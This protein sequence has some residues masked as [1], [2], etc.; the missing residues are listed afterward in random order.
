MVSSSR[1]SHGVPNP[2]S[3]LGNYPAHKSAR[4]KIEMKIPDDLTW[5]RANSACHVQ[6]L[7]VNCRDPYLEPTKYSCVA[8]WPQNIRMDQDMT[9]GALT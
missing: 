8:S 4:K 1:V 3:A 7:L 6:S 9:S 5:F 2:R